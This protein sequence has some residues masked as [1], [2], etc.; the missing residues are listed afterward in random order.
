MCKKKKTMGTC[1]FLMI[2][3][4][5]VWVET[6][7]SLNW[8]NK[9]S[10]WDVHRSCKWK[11]NAMKSQNLIRSIAICLDSCWDLMHVGMHCMTGMSASQAILSALLI[12]YISLKGKCQSQLNFSGNVIVSFTL[13]AINTWECR[14]M[15]SISIQPTSSCKLGEKAS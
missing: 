10:Q 8:Y 13:L 5:T 9:I 12:H 3:I 4:G 15:K 14:A 11:L 2:N 7:V 1:S 6:I